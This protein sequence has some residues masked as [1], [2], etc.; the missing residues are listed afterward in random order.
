MRDPARAIRLRRTPSSAESTREPHPREPEE[1]EKI[2]DEI[3]GFPFVALPI[4]A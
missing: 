2:V 4:S 1:I 3:V